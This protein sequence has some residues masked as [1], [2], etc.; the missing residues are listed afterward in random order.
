MN[1]LSKL[2]SVIRFCRNYRNPLQVLWARSVRPDGL[3][4]VV[5]RASG[6]ACQCKV[7]SYRMFGEVWHDRDYD[8]PKLAIRPGDVVLDIGAN[9]G[10]Y[11]CYAAWH[12]A[13]IH[14]F[15]PFP[16]SFGRLTENVAANGL[17]ARVKARCCAIGG[18]TGR[19][20]LLVS[21]RLGGGMDTIQESF[22]ANANLEVRLKIPVDVISLEQVMKENAIERVRICKLDCEGSELEIL[23][24][25]PLELAERFDALVIEFHSEVYDPK[26]LL[27]LLCGWKT[28]HVSYAE[29]KYCTSQIIRAVHQRVLLGEEWD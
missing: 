6:V 8:V 26:E 18:Q 4:T 23:A 19:R 9:Q 7:R 5:D 15:E 21:D 29:D 25:L 27:A 2:S 22:A 1:I 13:Q 12:G 10:F 24:G 3:V 11:T 16:E 17:N 28:H 14:A 20:E